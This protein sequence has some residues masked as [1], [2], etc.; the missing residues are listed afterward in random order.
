[1][2]KRSPSII[3]HMMG[4]NGHRFQTGSSESSKIEN[5]LIIPKLTP[6]CE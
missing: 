6:L 3:K 1:M 5:K 4:K 2:L